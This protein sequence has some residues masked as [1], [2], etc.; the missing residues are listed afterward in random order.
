MKMRPS[1]FENAD[2]AGSDRMKL[3]PNPEVI[4]DRRIAAVGSV[5]AISLMLMP[6]LLVALLSSLF[7]GVIMIYSAAANPKAD[8]NERMFVGACFIWFSFAMLFCLWL[9]IPVIWILA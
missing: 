2:D 1:V 6:W 7:F 4:T 9:L 8:K 3:A 5:I